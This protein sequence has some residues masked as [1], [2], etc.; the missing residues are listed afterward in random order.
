MK[1]GI[2]ALATGYFTVFV[3]LLTYVIVSFGAV[4]YLIGILLK[5]D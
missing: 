2:H 3:L 4:E 1:H 5:K